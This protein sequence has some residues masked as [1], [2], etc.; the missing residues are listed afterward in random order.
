MLC[1]Y[2]HILGKEGEGAH[3][4]RVFNIAIVDVLLTLLLGVIIS[5]LGRINIYKLWAFLFILGIFFHYIF[6]VNTTINV[7]LFGKR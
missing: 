6:C 3:S 5:Y 1:E 7:A 4:I 2:R